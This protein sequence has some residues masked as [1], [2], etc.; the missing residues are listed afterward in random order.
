MTF[1]L[2]HFI[3]KIVKHAEGL[4]IQSNTVIVLTLV[5]T[6][7]QKAPYNHHHLFEANSK[8][9]NDIARI[10]AGSK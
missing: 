10:S 9:S 5:S 8:N 3:D 4:K 1:T 7:P 2:M 6:T